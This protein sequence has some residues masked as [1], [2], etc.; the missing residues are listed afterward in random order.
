MTWIHVISFAAYLIFPVIFIFIIFKSR[1]RSFRIWLFN[2]ILIVMY[3]FDLYL[4][5]NWAIALGYYFRYFIVVFSVIAVVKSYR[6]ISPT[7]TIKSK[8]KATTSLLVQLIFI[9]IFAIKATYVLKSFF[10]E[11][12]SVALCYPLKNGNY[13]V[14]HGGKTLILNHHHPVSA[15]KYAMDIL[16]LNA[17]GLR[18]RKLWPTQLKD[19]CIYNAE[20]YSPCSGIVTKVIDEYEDLTP[21]TMDSSH[22]AGNYLIISN[23]QTGVSVFLAH[24]KKGSIKVCEGDL[25]KENDIIAQV[26]NS[27]NTSEPHLHLHA[28]KTE[29]GD[30]LSLAEG[31]AI[32][33]ENKCLIRNSTF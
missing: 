19:F 24:L 11:C 6:A 9:A 23:P 30:P 28:F 7:C 8:W 17:F 31:I 5:G 22:I 4:T 18:S 15:Q 33:F 2:T 25:V 1:P 32:K 26:G 10:I 21:G 27:G 13:F 29:T 14:A 3:T 20:I 12:E 16:Q